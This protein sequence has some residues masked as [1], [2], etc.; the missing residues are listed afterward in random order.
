VS[1][2]DSAQ[3]K[4]EDQISQRS[5][6]GIIVIEPM[7]DMTPK[8]S[9]GSVIAKDNQKEVEKEKENSSKGV[10]GKSP[11]N[12]AI[13]DD[14]KSD[15][16]SKSGLAKEMAKRRSKFIANPGED[17]LASP[18]KGISLTFPIPINIQKIRTKI[19]HN[20]PPRPQKKLPPLTN[21]VTP[22]LTNPT[23]PTLSPLP[24]PKV[25]NSKT[26]QNYLKVQKTHKTDKTPTRK[27]R[28]KVSPCAQRSK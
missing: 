15:M 25:P 18:L 24:H 1:A 5:A 26:I 19:L 12:H 13:P 16:S 4:R 6:R 22:N 8:E 11:V 14:N 10:S 17:L 27:K 23:K 7:Q 21:P 2:H 20:T 3:S 28:A 9:I